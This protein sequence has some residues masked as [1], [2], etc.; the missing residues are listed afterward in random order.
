MILSKKIRRIPTISFGWRTVNVGRK[1]IRERKSGN[2]SLYCIL[3]DPTSSRTLSGNCC[4]LLEWISDAEVKYKDNLMNAYDNSIRYTDNFLARIIHLLKQQKC[5]MPVC[6][7]RPTM[8]KIISMMADT[9]FFMHPPFRPTISYTY[10]LLW[11]SDS[12]RKSGPDRESCFD[13]PTEKYIFQHFF[14]QTMMELAGIETCIVMTV[15]LSPALSI[16]RNRGF[17][18]TIIMNRIHWMI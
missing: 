2:S 16:Q 9:C 13:E 4:F 17:I 10:L 7:T 11:T 6:F 18:W 1:I 5:Q 12:Y 8:G 3:M 14:F 15:Y